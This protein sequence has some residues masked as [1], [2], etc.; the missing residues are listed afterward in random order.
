MYLFPIYTEHTLHHNRARRCFKTQNYWAI[1]S[2][3][4]TA[5][6]DMFSSKSPL[7][8]WIP[9]QLCWPHC[10]IEN[11][12]QGPSKEVMFSVARNFVNRFTNYLI[13]IIYIFFKWHYISI[14][15][16]E[17][18]PGEE[19]DHPLSEPMSGM[20]SDAT[21]RSKGFVMAPW[22]IHCKTAELVL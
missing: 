14:V 6:F 9:Y 20:P 10:I 5:T 18:D 8:L 2:K 17:L 16:A 1:S 4:R 15:L 19:N 12:E 21:C 22:Y 3:L 13:L 7:I 11:G